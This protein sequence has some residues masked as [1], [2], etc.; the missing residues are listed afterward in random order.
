MC[1]H[2]EGHWCVKEEH[3]NLVFL[4]LFFAQSAVFFVAPFSL[5]LLLA[6]T[7]LLGSHPDGSNFSR[8]RGAKTQETLRLRRLASA[9]ESCQST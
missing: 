3:M 5:C 9:G 8:S 1:W 2:I 4:F 6:D 7:N